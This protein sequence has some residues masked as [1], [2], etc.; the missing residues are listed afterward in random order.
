MNDL[1]Q[2]IQAAVNLYK[3]GNFIKCQEITNK[4]ISINP[5]V[6]FL[7]NLLG[8][9]LTSL[10]KN[11]EAEEVYKKGIEIDPNYAMI[12]N[13]LGTIYYS[14]SSAA[15]N[16]ENN[17]K[18]AEEFYQKAIKLNSK[19]PEANSNLGNL[20]NSIGDNKKSIKYHK[21]AID[22]DS[23][24]LFSYL[25]IA[26]V[27]VEIGNFSEAIKYLNE[28]IKLDPNFTPSHRLLSRIIKY[29]KK[30][31][32]LSQLNDLYK[33]N[34]SQ[35]NLNKMNIAFALGKANE[36][37]GE[38][39]KSFNYYKTANK[40]NRKNID[41]SIL[42]EKKFFNEIKNTYNN[43]IFDKYS[44]FGSNNSS[45]IF[46]VGMPRSGTTLIEQILSSHSKVFGADEVLYI[47]QLID[48]YFGKN[49]LNLSLQGISNFDSSQLTKIAKDYIFLMESISK[50][51]K[52]TV[53]KLPANFLNIGLIKLILPKSKII[54]C[55]RNPKDN[56]FSIF[57]NHFSANKI[58]FASDLYETVE[59]YNLYFDLME[60]WNN[61]LPNFILNFKYEDLIK[62]TENEVKKLLKFCE[63][64]WESQ[65][66]EFYKNK[67]PIKTASDTQARNKI[68]NTSVN[69]WKIY[70]RFLE[71]YY[72]K[73]KVQ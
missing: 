53:D 45:C 36:D 31:S 22:S 14:K 39:E 71:D 70:E 29:T 8:L 35:D 30:T 51:S 44:K 33:K 15:K 52:K 68:Y 57:K 64:K 6:V 61:L 46:I 4:L 41:F 2:K 13:N 38:I 25:N 73:L 58:K 34:E 3:S 26:N 17:I 32:H 20:Y 24:Y 40:I 67:R 63:L 50:N 56:I 37:I 10:K 19:I 42:E 27:Y 18:K 60:F 65:C 28:S 66:L 49:K 59:Y 9:V 48:E 16:F 5:K 47:P 23:K 55:Y 43:D 69:K 62:N 7:Y 12:Y 11:D 1:K 54:H 72:K 21:L